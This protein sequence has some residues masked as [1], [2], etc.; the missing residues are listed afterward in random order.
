MRE[1]SRGMTCRR[2]IQR[3]AVSRNCGESVHITPLDPATLPHLGV[4]NTIALTEN[5]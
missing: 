4:V 5:Q 3:F 2:A 1:R